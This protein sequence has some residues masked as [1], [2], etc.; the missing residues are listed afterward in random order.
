[1]QSLAYGW[2]VPLGVA[3]QVS[4]EDVDSELDGGK[5]DATNTDVRLAAMLGNEQFGSELAEGEE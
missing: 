3:S 5:C 2:L 4:K 1:M